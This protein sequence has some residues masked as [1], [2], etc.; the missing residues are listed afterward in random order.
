MKEKILFIGTRPIYPMK[1][2]RTVLINQYCGQL[3]DYFNYDVHYACFGLMEM[4]QPGYLKASYTLEEPAFWEMGKNIILKSFLFHKWPVQASVMYSKKTQRKLDNIIKKVQPSYIF[5]DMARTA[6]Y[7]YKRYQG[8]CIKIL[9]MDDLLSKRYYRQAGLENLDDSVLGQFRKKIPDLF[10]TVA[11]KFHLIRKILCFEAKMMEKYELQAVKEFDKTFFCSSTDMEEFNRK[12]VRKA[13]CVHTAVDLH[14]FSTAKDIVYNSK[15]IV[16]LGNID[17]SANRDSLTYLIEKIMSKVLQIDSAY[18]LL[19]V[20]NC[21]QE[22]YRNFEKYHFVEFSFRVD[23]IRTYVQKCVA[24]VAP[25]CY[26]SGIKIKIIEAMAMGVPVI[27]NKYGAEGL[28]VRSYQE[29]IICDNDGQFIKA[30]MEISGNKELRELL[31]VNGRKYVEKN[32]SLD[33]CRQDMEK[34]LE[35]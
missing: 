24:L 3:A 18:K 6:P 15:T 2:G 35:E 17:I 16:Y 26:G 28:T 4:K 23:D 22:T 11:A 33:R 19:V 1:D 12:S 25:L 27:T 10:V 31:S 20:G 7:L 5:C 14:Y 13:F 32:H 9:D 30:I 8:D 29:M 34:I 21:S